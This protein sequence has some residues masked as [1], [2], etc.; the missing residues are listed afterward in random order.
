MTGLIRQFTTSVNNLRE[1]LYSKLQKNH[2]V[3][4]LL[5]IHL[6]P[7]REQKTWIRKR[8]SQQSPLIVTLIEIAVV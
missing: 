1:G 3:S 6:A 4:V 8:S 7:I 5:R 2:L